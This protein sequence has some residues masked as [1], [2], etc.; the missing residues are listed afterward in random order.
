MKNIKS[1]QLVNDVWE[2]WKVRYSKIEFHL[3]SGLNNIDNQLN[4]NLEKKNG[5]T[6]NKDTANEGRIPR[7]IEGMSNL[8]NLC[9]YDFR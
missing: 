9:I 5:N 1:Q 7:I 6:K 8:I 3:E 4:D 2:V